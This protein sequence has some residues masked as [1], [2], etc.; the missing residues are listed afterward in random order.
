ML[1]LIGF[2]IVGVLLGQV[3]LVLLARWEKRH[4]LEQSSRPI[5][6]HHP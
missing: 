4:A 2:F 3:G 5:S 1:L 6:R